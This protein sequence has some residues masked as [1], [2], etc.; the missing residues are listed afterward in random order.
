MIAVMHGSF[1][2]IRPIHTLQTASLT[3]MSPRSSI[4]MLIASLIAGSA[5]VSAIAVPSVMEALQNGLI[6]TSP[7]LQ[8]ACAKVMSALV[9]HATP[10][11]LLNLLER[12]CC[13]YVLEAMRPAGPASQLLVQALGRG[14]AGAPVVLHEHLVDECVAV[15]RGLSHAGAARL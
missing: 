11:L 8:L 4:I 14:A 13:E 15:L 5:D 12:S 10:A 9:A 1:L 2:N 7:G 3:A 6:S